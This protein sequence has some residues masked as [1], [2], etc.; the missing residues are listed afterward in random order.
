MVKTKKKFRIQFTLPPI[1]T[2]QA[3]NFKL[4]S[5]KNTEPAKQPASKV[6]SYSI[7]YK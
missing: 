6:Y 1:K 5:N 3:V 4:V 2:P 7:K